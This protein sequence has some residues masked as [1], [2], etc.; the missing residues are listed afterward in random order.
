[1]PMP[2]RVQGSNGVPARRRAAR[3]PGCSLQGVQ[4]RLALAL[5]Q[6]R[7]AA[8]GV[9][10]GGLEQLRDLGG[11]V[12]GEA[13]EQVRDLGLADDL[14]RLRAAEDGGDGLLAPRDL[15]AELLARG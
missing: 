10:P 2:D 4:Q 12:A 3:E 15:V 11:A 6:A 8:G 1:R 13:L 7:G 9:D 14:V 5:A